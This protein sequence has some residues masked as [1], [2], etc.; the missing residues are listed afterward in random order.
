MVRAFEQVS[1]RKVPYRIVERRPGDIAT[2]YADPS[3]ARHDFSWEAKIGVERMCG[4]AW[5]WQSRHPQG[6]R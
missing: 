1:G 2:S 3:R 4:D 5:H 6:F